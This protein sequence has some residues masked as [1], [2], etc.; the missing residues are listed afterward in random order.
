MHRIWPI[1]GKRSECNGG[2]N[3]ENLAWPLAQYNPGGFISKLEFND[4][5]YI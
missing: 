4:L 3:G 1:F 2:S 5:L